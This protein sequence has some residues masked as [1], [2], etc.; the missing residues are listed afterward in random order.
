MIISHKHRFIFIKTEK[1]AGTSI[2]MALAAVCGPQDIITPVVHPEDRHVIASAG[3]AIRPPQNY[4]IP[5]NKWRLREWGQ[6]FKTGT[7]PQFYN[8]I[9]AGEIRQL[10][11]SD[12]WDN[13]YKFC[14]ERNPWDKVVSYY[15]WW[16]KL[17]KDYQQDG[18]AF[19]RSLG[20]SGR[21]VEW[22]IKNHPIGEATL[23]EAIQSGR[24]NWVQGFDLY[25][26]RNEIVVNRVAKYESLNTEFDEIMKLLGITQKIELPRLKAGARDKRHYRDL[27]TSFDRD[28]IGK[29]FAREI[30]YFGYEF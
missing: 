4:H 15:Y 11:A 13:Y 10:I 2:E 22:I 28:K 18:A 1:T 16:R 17:E 19:I 25:S 8:H 3:D 27:L 30:A 7:W 21:G 14:F 29:A 9:G 26:I 20:A 6:T 5:L 23:S 24:C 12:V